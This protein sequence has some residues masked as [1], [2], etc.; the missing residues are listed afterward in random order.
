MTSMLNRNNEIRK[1]MTRHAELFEVP[2]SKYNAL[3][4]TIRHRDAKC[5]IITN[6]MDCNYGF[7][8]FKCQLK[9]FCH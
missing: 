5:G 9:R 7:I 1:Y 3:H 6:T 4:K 2:V 8:T